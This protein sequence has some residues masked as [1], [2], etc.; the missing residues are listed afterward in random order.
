M[1]LG[2]AVLLLVAARLLCLASEASEYETDHRPHGKEVHVSA[3]LT[4]RSVLETFW[5][6]GVSA[7]AALPSV[8]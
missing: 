8:P 3:T 1:V 6:I 2:M 5:S 7:M 4:L